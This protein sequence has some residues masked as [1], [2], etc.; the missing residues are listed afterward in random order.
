MQLHNNFYCYCPGSDRNWSEYFSD[1]A[2]WLDILAILITLFVIPL[3][4]ASLDEQWV[5]VALAYILHTLRL[6]K[7]AIFNS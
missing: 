2:N 3:R 5:F 4:I 6:F 1:W 7:Y